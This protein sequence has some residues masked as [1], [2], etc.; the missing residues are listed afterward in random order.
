VPGVFRT[1]FQTRPLDLG[2]DAF[3]TSRKEA[4]DALLQEVADGGAGEA[5]VVVMQ[6][7]L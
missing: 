6:A 3:Y 7:R 1:P 5:E 4:V 2:T